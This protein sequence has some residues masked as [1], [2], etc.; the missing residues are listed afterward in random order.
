[1]GSHNQMSDD[2]T[3]LSQMEDNR[4]KRPN[5]S[6]G[7]RQDTTSPALTRR[8]FL[9]GATVSGFVGAKANDVSAESSSSSISPKSV[10]DY[11]QKFKNS[12]R[13][14]GLGSGLN[15]YHLETSGSIVSHDVTND[16]QEI[17]N[18]SVVEGTVRKGDTDLYWCSGDVRTVWAKGSITYSITDVPDKS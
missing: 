11:K 18:N 1:M 13:V 6:T 2:D 16:L 5:T 14:K 4:E 12:L 15:H 9:K 10:G 3:K 8:T 7:T 17:G